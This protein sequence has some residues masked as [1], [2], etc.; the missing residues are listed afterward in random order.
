MVEECPP[1]WHVI[2]PRRRQ[3]IDREVLRLH[4]L[5]HFGIRQH[6]LG[7]IYASELLGN[8]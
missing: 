4:S 5:R 3:C 8:R 6:S 1:C 2:G 7:S